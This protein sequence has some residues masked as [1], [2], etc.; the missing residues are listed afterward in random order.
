MLPMMSRRPPA[1]EY[2]PGK[3]S[4]TSDSSVSIGTTRVT[5]PRPFLPSSDL[6]SASSEVEVTLPGTYSIAGGLRDIIGM[7][8]GIS[9]VEEI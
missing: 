9:Q 3:V 8:P 2:V 4:S 5:R 6:R 7:L 1:I